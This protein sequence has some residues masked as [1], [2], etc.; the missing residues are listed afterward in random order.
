MCEHFLGR[1]VAVFG[2]AALAVLDE[3][4]MLLGGNVVVCALVVDAVAE[5][6]V[7]AD[8]VL[9]VAPAGELAIAEAVNELLDRLLFGHDGLL[10]WNLAV[11]EVDVVGFLAWLQREMG[12]QRAV[13]KN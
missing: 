8:G 6:S 1:Q 10:G 5:F 9:F 3:E 13:G 2:L 7:V 4:P 11:V 12:V